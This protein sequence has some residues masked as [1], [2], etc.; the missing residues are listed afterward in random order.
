[1]RN[2]PVQSTT[3]GSLLAPT[4]SPFELRRKFLNLVYQDLLGPKDGAE[5][6]VEEQYV[7]ERYLVGMLA[8]LNQE[9][10]PI[11]DSLGV[12]DPA[13]DNE[14]SEEESSLAG[15]T[16]F[17]SSFGFSCVV[18]ADVKELQIGVSWGQYT[19]QKSTF[20]TTD[21][22]NPKTVWKR[23]PREYLSEAVQLREGDLSWQ[24]TW[25]KAQ[26][27]ERTRWEPCA[28]QPA[29]WV[30]GRARMLRDQWVVTFFLVNGQEEPT[31]RKTGRDSTWLFQPEMW[32]KSPDGE[33]VFRPTLIRNDSAALDKEWTDERDALNMAYRHCCE[34]A[35]GHGI[36][37]HATHDPQNS[38]RA[39]EIRTRAIPEL[40][41]D[42]T[43]APTVIQEPSLE[44][45]T[46][47]MQTLASCSD[48][49]LFAALDALCTAY[50][51]W[52]KKENEKLR[53]NLRDLQSHQVAAQAS[54][55]KCERALQRMRDGVETLRRSDL[56]R[57][58]WRFTNRAM[59]LQRIHSL[60][61]EEIRRGKPTQL[62][63]VDIAKNR[64]WR[65][66]QLAFVLLNLPSLTDVTHADRQDKSDALA[67][68]LFFPTGGGKT[69]A[70]LG[71]TA[72]T[73]GIRR[74]Q[75]T[76]AGRDGAHGV[77][78]LMRY[79]LRLLTLQQ[80]Q[81]ATALI[82]ACESIRREA[83]ESGD[84][85][86]GAEPF[87]LG[88][89]VG[90]KTTP[91]STAASHD[92]I[93]SQI[94]GGATPAQLTNCPWCGSKID[95][96][97]HI[98]VDQ[99]HKRT[100]IYCGDPTGKCLFSRKNSETEGIPALVVDE[101]IYR[102]LPSLLISTVD[103]WAQMPW[104]GKTQMLFGRV[105]GF[106]ERHGFRS[107]EVDDT[108]SH[109]ATRGMPAARTIPM[110]A[111]RPPDL[112]IQDEL[113]LISGPLGT[114]VGLYETAVDELCSWEVNGV[115]VRPKVIA[116][117]ATIRNA[118]RQ[119]HSLFLRQ[120]EVFPPQGTDIR[121]NFF[122]RQ[123]ESSI[124][125]PGRIYFG[126]CA[127]GKR[128]KAALIRVYVAHLS[129][130]QALYQQYGQ[131]ADPWM[132]LVGYFNSMREL[133]GMRR[134][135]DDD[136]S[137]RLR[138]ME[139]R[140]LARRMVSNTRELT[141][142]L[143]AVQIPEILDQLE[144]PFDPM[145]EERRK[146]ARK[147]GSN[148]FA[149][150]NPLPFDVL[151]ATNMISVG[152]DVRRLGLMIVSGQ[153]K[154]SSEYIQATSRVGR[155]TPGV[156]CTVFNWARPRDLSHYESFEHYH[157]TFYQHVESLSVTPF[158]PRAL[159]RGLSGVLVSLLRLPSEELNANDRA[160][161]M[162]P[163]SALVQY[164][165]SRIIKRG[166]DAM[167]RNDIGN[168]IDRLIKERLDVWH[169][170]TM[171]KNSGSLLGYQGANELKALLTKPEGKDWD[172]FTCLNSL[173]DVEPTA[174]LLLVEDESQE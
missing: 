8:P 40:E 37:T 42:P 1:M 148:R 66:F 74:L 151:L 29:V 16:M 105:N 165:R 95:A 63:D 170:L 44:N 109:T 112:I 3:P 73:L 102:R 27:G 103:K 15:N 9:E 104:N 136:V 158:A 141:S 152:V 19:R 124:E 45:V 34:F 156:V 150:E 97:K 174:N 157:A 169:S 53:N 121:D 46:L 111:L 139:R 49:E 41:V 30:Q 72:Y 17:P 123:Q 126:I 96:G 77:A 122:S 2:T 39:Y 113:H 140:G 173:R 81:R 4:I 57:Q 159:D 91:N 22:G 172:V 146:A 106:C 25:G 100:I 6:E 130:A 18:P 144:V 62:A 67:D 61:S 147:A 33:P 142:R 26:G 21:E 117:T 162:R 43:L 10:K 167:E 115:R 110:N 137:S 55:H 65:P 23:S 134:L 164:A 94:G 5:E 168:E 143:S 14:E 155:Q 82:C 108:D 118:R 36:A 127:P 83:L 129:A 138:K 133:G 163:D 60:A 28:D 153:P 88:L 79:T 114:L 75:G 58:A 51:A 68:L 13:G 56:A 120:V 160:Q 35:S 31:D 145:I 149:N 116:S 92:A 86:W 131:A 48:E 84:A 38:N 125:T 64:S 54:I 71:L 93:A 171:Q 154:S 24:P 11:L 85:R 99:D 32:A 69:E 59:H 87:R 119:V 70:Y 101:E 47:D 78:V 107:P 76:V 135:V 166:M 7:S 12:G 132:T 20:S 128:L 161:A 98:K 52:I 89:W 90:S 80:F 50:D